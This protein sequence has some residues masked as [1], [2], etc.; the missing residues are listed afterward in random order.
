MSDPTTPSSRLDAPIPRA[1]ASP[2]AGR[3]FAQDVAPLIRRINR[4]ARASRAANGESR[5]VMARAAQADGIGMAPSSIERLEMKANRSEVDLI[6]TL[7]TLFRGG[8]TLQ[9]LYPTAADVG[10]LTAE[11]RALL[12]H[13]RSAKPSMRGLIVSQAQLM[14]RAV[15]SDQETSE[16][17]ANV[18]EWPQRE[19]SAEVTAA[20]EQIRERKRGKGSRPRKMYGNGTNGKASS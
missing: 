1:V 6:R 18:H 20:Q 7:W 13:Y 3:A 12:R 8:Y 4:L 16:R 10:D 14:A 2:L 5:E 17:P 11:E 19:A 15:D 9:D